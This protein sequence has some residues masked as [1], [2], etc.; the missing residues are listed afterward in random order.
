VSGSDVTRDRK[1]GTR[2]ERKK[3]EKEEKE[4]SNMLAFIAQMKRMKNGEGG[5]RMRFGA[6]FKKAVRIKGSN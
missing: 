6:R 1:K 2:K 4:A 5:R 3:K